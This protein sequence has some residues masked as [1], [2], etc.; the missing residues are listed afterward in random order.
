MLLDGDKSATIHPSLSVK[1][2][3]PL[4]PLLFSIY[5]NAIDSLAEGVQGTIMGIPNLTVTHLLFA[6]DHSLTFTDHNE[7]Q[8]MQN[9]LR[10]YAQKKSLT[11]NTEK[12]E[13]MCF[14]SRP[15]SF[16]PPL[17]FNG[18][19]LPYTDTLLYL[20]MVCDRQI[21]LNIAADAALQ[22]FMAGTFKVK[23]FVK[24]H[25]LANILDAHIIW[26]LK[27]YAIP[28]SMYASQKWTTPFLR[29]GR[30]MDNPLQK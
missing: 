13:V 2:G 20:S 26:L 14:N 22:P 25:D 21:N 19:Q 12:S 23:Q 17:F 3:C 16:L 24:S 6:D 29:Q 7:L 28:A 1:Q 10:V 5:L 9:K 8:T 30:E 15:G 4:S 11:V 18:T 27:T